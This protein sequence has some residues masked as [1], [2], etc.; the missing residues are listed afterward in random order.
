MST[1]FSRFELNRAELQRQFRQGGMVFVWT[2]TRVVR[3]IRNLAVLY[4][5]V[6]TGYMRNTLATATVSSA[7]LQVTGMVG[8]TAKYAE[9][10][11]EGTRPHVIVPRTKKALAF[12]GHVAPNTVGKSGM[13][14][15]FTRTVNHPGTKGRPFL[16][17]AMQEV[18]ATLR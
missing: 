4:A 8:A 18:V 17:R 9:Y 7:A 14:L 6:D 12:K 11:H 16:R 13:Q 5:P 3:P 15:V 2:T 10:V 1:E